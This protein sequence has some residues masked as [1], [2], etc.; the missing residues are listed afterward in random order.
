MKKFKMY[1]RTFHVYEMN[2]QMKDIHVY[3]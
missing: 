1:E 3:S 2:I